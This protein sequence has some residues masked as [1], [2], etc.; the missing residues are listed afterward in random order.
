MRD[1][2]GIYIPQGIGVGID[3]E[4]PSLKDKINSS[5]NNLCTGLSD[6]VDLSLGA[7]FTPALAGINPSQVYSS[8][9]NIN[10]P[11]EVTVINNIDSKPL[12]KSLA[13]RVEKNITRKQENYRS[14]KGR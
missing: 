6:T 4:M 14:I 3:E 12:E 10:T 11:I 8:S 7:T 5:I 13:T 1:M 2:V 9:T